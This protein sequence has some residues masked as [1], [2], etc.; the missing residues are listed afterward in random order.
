MDDAGSKINGPLRVIVDYELKDIVQF[1][2]ECRRKEIPELRNALQCKNFSVIARIAHNI[3]GAGG[4]YGFDKISDLGES[5]ED[6]AAS[7]NDSVV[8]NKLTE[9]A[10]YLDQV[11][12]IIGEPASE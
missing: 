5:I 4:G 9:L 7:L 2:M 3:K 12:I 8:D 10:H 6:A 1:F 11:E